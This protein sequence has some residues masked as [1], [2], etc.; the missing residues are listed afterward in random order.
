LD[1]FSE[2]DLDKRV[3]NPPAG[4]EEHFATYGK[5]LLTLAL[6]QGLHRSHI[7]DAV[8]AAGRAVPLP[9]AA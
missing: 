5:A 8:R 4:L 1:S 6:H 9:V 7:T 3:S 2:A